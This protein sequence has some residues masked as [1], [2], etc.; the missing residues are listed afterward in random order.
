MGR[1]DVTDLLILL[2]IQIIAV[3]IGFAAGKD[4][5]RQKRT[6][7]WFA[8]LSFAAAFIAHIIAFRFLPADP[9]PALRPEW[10]RFVVAAVWALATGVTIEFSARP[11]LLVTLISAGTTLIGYLAFVYLR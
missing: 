3:F 2:G 9:P 8:M 5:P 1:F 11:P 4:I 7:F 6:V 10:H